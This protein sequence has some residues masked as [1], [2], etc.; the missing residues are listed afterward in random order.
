MTSVGPLPLG[1]LELELP[2]LLW[3]EQQARAESRNAAN[4]K[5]SDFASPMVTLSLFGFP[6]EIPQSKVYL[7]KAKEPLTREARNPPP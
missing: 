2:S 4:P 7:R 1:E 5:A 6:I 3:A